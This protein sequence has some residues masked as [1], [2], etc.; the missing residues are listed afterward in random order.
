MAMSV[1]VSEGYGKG[2]WKTFFIRK[3]FGHHVAMSVRVSEGYG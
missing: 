1:R 2:L 3:L